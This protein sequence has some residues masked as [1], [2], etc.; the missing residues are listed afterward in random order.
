MKACHFLDRFLEEVPSDLGLEREA[1]LKTQRH[2]F[3][4]FF[5]KPLRTEGLHDEK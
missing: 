4:L 1:I 2:S 5:P 3:V